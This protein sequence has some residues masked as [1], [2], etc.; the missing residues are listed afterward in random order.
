MGVVV[1]LAYLAVQVRSNTRSAQAA[2]YQS[3]TQ[4]VLDMNREIF[5]NPELARFLERARTADEPFDPVEQRRWEAYCSTHFRHFDNIFHQHQMGSLRDSEFRSLISVLVSLMVVALTRQLLN[6]VGPLHHESGPYVVVFVLLLTVS[7]MQFIRLVSTSVGPNDEPPD[8]QA[9]ACSCHPT[10][11]P[12]R[13]VV[14][15]RWAPCPSAN[16]QR[17]WAR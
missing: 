15:W 17:C 3:M 13:F 12:S 1:S 5:A 8:Q 2:T 16:D 10:A 11:R 14:F 7:A 6:P 4:G 9:V